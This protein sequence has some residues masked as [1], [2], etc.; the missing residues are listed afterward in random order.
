MAVA[1]PAHVS[2]RTRLDRWV[3]GQL[4]RPQAAE[5]LWVLAALLGLA[6]LGLSLH[7][8]SVFPSSA[9]AMPSGFGAPVLG[10]EF[11]R[12]VADLTA[13]FGPEGDPLRD[14]R[15]AAMQAGNERDYLFMLVYAAFLALGC[16]CLWRTLRRP[17]LLLGVVMPVL[18]AAFDA[19]ENWLLF[20]IQAAFV[21]GQYHPSMASLPLPV[22]MKFL[23][24]T[25]TNVLIGYALT[26]LGGRWW[27]IV[28]TLVLVPC[29]TVV[30]ALIAPIA[31]AW[32]LPA[33]IGAG[34]IALFGTAV[35]GAWRAVVTRQP[36][37]SFDADLAL[38]RTAARPR[39]APAAA[40]PA[41]DA[42]P[43]FGRRTPPAP[44][45]EDTP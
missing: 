5:P 33:A 28:G 13:I 45:P 29:I 18:A 42:R 24:L 31:F 37:A 22:A 4:A 30:M 10:F 26:Q 7:L 25:A 19:Y 27:Q 12:T 16:W 43:V 23:F 17:L 15:L 2:M 14:V 38:M 8:T 44:P 1:K 32:T 21:L 20:D 6:T 39:P 34:W 36:L 3:A 41:P 11:A 9:H 40:E 35:L